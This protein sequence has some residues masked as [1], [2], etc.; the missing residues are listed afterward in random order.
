MKKLLIFLA[1]SFSMT[2]L[3]QSGSVLDLGSIEIEGEVRR[4]MLNYINTDR[5]FDQLVDD[6][7][8]TNYDSL[9]QRLTVINLP[10][11]TIII[12]DENGKLIEEK[13]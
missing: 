11:Q 4:P 7:I 1:L 3:G 5:K 13:L 10:S 8:L 12:R 2:A 6:T 9:E